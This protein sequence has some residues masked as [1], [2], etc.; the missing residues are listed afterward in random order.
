VETNVDLS[1]GAFYVIGVACALGYEGTAAAATCSASS[2]YTVTGC[3][4]IVC[5][6]PS[7]ITGYDFTVIETSLSGGSFDVTEDPSSS[8]LTRLFSIICDA[9]RALRLHDPSS[10]RLTR[11]SSGHSTCYSRWVAQASAKVLNPSNAGGKLA[12]LWLE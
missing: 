2:A 1:T 11:L 12:C 10:S 9:G 8:R 3:T 4:E 6:Q 7:D 5:T